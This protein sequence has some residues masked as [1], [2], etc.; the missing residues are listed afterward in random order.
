MLPD[1]QLLKSCA[2]NFGRTGGPGGQHRN[3]VETACEILHRPTG[4][5]GQA[6]ER[7]SQSQNRHRATF[8]LRLRLARD[9]RRD[10]NPANYQP[11]ELWRSRRQ[12]KQMSI[13]PKH[14]DYPGILAEAI[15]VIVA[16]D[17]DV[18]GAA[19]VLGVSMSQLAKVV[20]NDR[21]SFARV[22]TERGKRGLHTL[23]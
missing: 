11:T 9:V 5:I 10:I 3:K 19:G 13:N 14:K 21:K 15:D 8:R 12:G 22:N 2:V 18:A 6:G 1:D 7:R 17:F 23:K 16:R 4:L 20:R